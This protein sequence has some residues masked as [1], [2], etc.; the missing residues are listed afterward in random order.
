MCEVLRS[1]HYKRRHGRAPDIADRHFAMHRIC[2]TL[3]PFSF[4][5]ACKGPKNT[6]KLLT[7]LLASPTL[8]LKP[9][10]ALPESRDSIHISD[11]KGTTREICPRCHHV[12][13][14]VFPDELHAQEC[15]CDL[16]LFRWVQYGVIRRR[17]E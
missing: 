4:C 9:A 3:P 13:C 12:S 6:Q 7:I 10:H 14:T 1:R 17:W 2:H 15:Q 8:D 11:F 16:S 5:R